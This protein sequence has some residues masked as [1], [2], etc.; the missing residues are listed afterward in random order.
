MAA[1]LTLVLTPEE[2]LTLEEMVRHHPYPE[3]RRRA[4]GLLALAA[5]QSAVTIAAVLRVTRYTVYTW[6]HRFETGGLAA[7][8]GG[9]QGGRPPILTPEALA[10]AVDLARR[11]PLILR[12]IAEQIQSAFPGQ[13]LPSEGRL[14]AALK[15][16]GCSFKRCRLYLKKKTPPLMKPDAPIS[17]P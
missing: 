16:A 7:L 2:T 3:F 10:F 8:L 1:P 4:Q 17:T 12:E 14:G 15:Q 13:T 9:R 6:V 5:G 11:E